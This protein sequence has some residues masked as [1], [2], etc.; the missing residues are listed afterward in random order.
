MRHLL[1]P[2]AI[3]GVPAL[4]IVALA[5]SSQHG[6]AE[7]GRAEST[8]PASPQQ[9]AAPLVQVAAASAPV[10]APVPAALPDPAA[11]L[12]PAA[13]P[14]VLRSGEF[15]L[16]TQLDRS[17]VLAGGDG[18]VR[19]ELVL[20]SEHLPSTTARIPTDLVVVMD[21]SGSMSGGKLVDAKTSA[22][23]LL[24]LLDEEDRFGLVTFS[25]GATTRI[26]L[27][28]APPQTRAHWSR[29]IDRL[30]AGGGT[31]MYAG[32]SA[33]R[34]VIA[35]SSAAGRARRVILIS[36]G[37]PNSPDGLVDLARGAATAETPLS[38][39]GIGDDYDEELMASLA[40]AGTGNFHWARRGED[41]TAVFADE[42]T[43]AA[44]C[45]ASSVEVELG[46]APGVQLVDAS[47]YAVA[48]DGYRATF[49]VGSMYAG[50]E[51][52]FWVTLRVPA[53]GN[54]PIDLGA[55]TVRF[56]TPEG[57]QVELASAVGSVA[58]EE[59]QRTW[60]ASL[61]ADAW[62]RAVVEEEYNELRAEVARQVQAGDQQGALRAI[63]SYRTRNRVLN[64]D[65]G[66]ATV[67][68]NLAELDALE[69]DLNQQ[70][71]GAN[72]ASRQNVWAK[73]TRSSAYQQRRRGQARSWSSASR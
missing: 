20:G 56:T 54:E 64:D 55:S 21:T 25:G 29:T 42:F 6:A 26:P 17:P 67:T 60:V 4:A 58:V 52:H 7:Q 47:G 59:D 14:P 63:R 41:L 73:G 43:T 32:L 70:F 72:Q 10:V 35:T 31:D 2:L 44:D 51:R 19:V 66:S 37:L 71:Q 13:V 11:V 69:A 24:G 28:P 62:G 18:L 39:V 3:T 16:S 1:K 49:P 27:T 15:T 22:K 68:D 5:L 65:V 34:Q 36:D 46:L 53:A 48:R 57:R 50:Q 23:A 40:D 61:D 12:A 45:V 30:S 9:L 8:Q 33:G 38:T